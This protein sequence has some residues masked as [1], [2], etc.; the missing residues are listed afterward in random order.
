MPTYS[1]RCVLCRHGSTEVRRMAERDFGR[2]CLVCGRG[3][4]ERLVDAGT[5]IGNARKTGPGHLPAVTGASS[6]PI[7]IGMTSGTLLNCAFMKGST[8]VTVKRGHVDVNGM[9]V[10]NTPNAFDL[11]GGATVDAKNVS[12]DVGTSR[13]K[14][15]D[16][17]RKP[18]KRKR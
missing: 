2:T 17:R 6:A 11:S 16:S 7:G 12:H 1:Y 4:L 10:L 8:A 13:K 15:A 5:L 14:R 3:T 9:Q 18:R